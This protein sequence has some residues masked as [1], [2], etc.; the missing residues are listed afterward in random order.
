M[1]TH[2]LITLEFDKVA[3]NVAYYSSTLAGQAAVSAMLPLTDKRVIQ[4]KLDETTQARELHQLRGQ[5]PFGGIADVSDA[6]RRAAVGGLL[7][8]SDLVDIASTLVGAR[9][10]RGFLTKEADPPIPFLA[11]VARDIAVIESVPSAVYRAIGGRGD[12]LDSAS[13]ELGQIRNKKRGAEARLR[14]R[15]NTIVSGSMK[16]MLQD[17]VVVERAGRWCVPVKSEHRSAFGGIVHDTSSSGATLFI[18]PAAVVE[19]GNQLRELE[20]QEIREIERILLRLSAMVQEHASP[21]LLSL[22]R[23]TELD[24]I[25]SR[26]RYA[27]AVNACEPVLSDKP[28]VRLLSARHPLIDA[29]KVVPTDITVG[30]PENQVVLITGPNTGGKTVALKTVGLACLMAQS[31][32]HVQ[33]ERAELG[34]FQSVLADIGD[35]QSIQQSL[36]TFGGHMKN[37]AEILSNMFEPA[38]VLLDE[39]G[40]GTDPEEGAALA[41]AILEHMR[42]AGARIVATTHY[43]ELKSYAY[44]TPGV[45]NASV[46]F[47]QATLSPTYRLMQGIPGSS[48]ALTIAGRL[49]IP[50]SIIAEAGAKDEHAKKNAGELIAQIETARL[51][52][53][54]DQEAAKAAQKDVEALKIRLERQLA[55]YDSLKRELRHTLLAEA[56][57]AIKD[58]RTKAETAIAKVRESGKHAVPANLKGV[59]EEAEATAIEEINTILEVPESDSRDNAILDE[60]GEIKV[61]DMVKIAGIGVVGKVLE[62]VTDSE[63]VT[64]QVGAVRMHVPLRT[65]TRMSASSSAKV[66]PSIRSQPSS[67]LAVA[68]VPSQLNLIGYRADEAGSM[69]ENYLNDAKS[70]HLARLRIVHGKGSGTLRRVVHSQLQHHPYVEK[71]ELAEPEEGGAGATIVFLKE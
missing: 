64:V 52:A 11:H 8:P 18:E 20:A 70:A 29:A 19:A 65:L 58:A 7:E 63:R 69:L 71:I 16:S 24:V 37:I 47:D 17:P 36:S 41:R 21:I 10:L 31:G 44:S 59:I 67:M 43:G 2:A 55:E 62:D 53:L 57:A 48:N 39:I 42:S 45:D 40:A 32:L 14:E 6:V 51:G 23:V 15:L 27:D 60:G 49:G 33:A 26:A 50:A 28:V 1:D 13:V 54:Q 61:R 3:K 4:R 46:E 34:V 5:M 68:D 30:Q 22:A 25:C 38:L 12:V 35:E 56:R 9:A 66:R